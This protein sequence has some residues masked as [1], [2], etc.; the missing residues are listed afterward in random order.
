MKIVR[1][2]HAPRLGDS[3]NNG[4][5]TNYKPSDGGTMEWNGLEER[6]YWTLLY[7][8]F[9]VQQ[10]IVTKDESYIRIRRSES[11][12]RRQFKTRKQKLRQMYTFI[13]QDA[14]CKILPI[15]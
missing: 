8:K 7:L 14:K 5:E 4:T 12:H 3:M 1:G 6:N 15:T 11:P 13:M 9:V 10:K 2:L